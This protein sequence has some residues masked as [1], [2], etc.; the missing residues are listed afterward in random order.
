MLFATPAHKIESIRPPEPVKESDQFLVS[1][2]ESALDSRSN[3]DTVQA[4]QDWRLFL[5]ISHINDLVFPRM[6][7]NGCTQAIL[8][9]ICK[10]KEQDWW[11]G[12]GEDWA[13]DSAHLK[14]HT[15]D[16]AFQLTK[17]FLSFCGFLDSLSCHLCMAMSLQKITCQVWI[18]SE[19]QGS[20]FRC[21]L[22]PCHPNRNS[23]KKSWL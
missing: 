12:D 18:N 9:F 7:Q 1:A 3:K 17:S 2:E 15:P 19:Y 16:H 23:I 20:D 6:H 8:A 13:L 4:S 21:C 10:W 22:I 5:F 11:T 14:K